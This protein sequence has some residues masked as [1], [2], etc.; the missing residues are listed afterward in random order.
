[1]TFDSTAKSILRITY[2]NGMTA[3]GEVINCLVENTTD[4]TDITGFG[5]L[6][7]GTVR[8][9]T[10]IKVRIDCENFIYEDELELKEVDQ[11]AF[12]ALL[13]GR[14]GGYSEIQEEEAEE[15]TQES[16]S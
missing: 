14:Y 11:N 16:Q 12:D 4:T 1:M 9:G 5:G 8:C 15:N 2:K 7:L 3:K 13:E 10:A 6:T